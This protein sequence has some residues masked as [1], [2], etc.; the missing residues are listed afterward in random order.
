MLN[1]EYYTVLECVDNFEI[2][3]NYIESLISIIEKND[4]PNIEEILN[5][6]GIIKYEN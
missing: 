3:P 2:M 1:T 4:N 5:H 6:H